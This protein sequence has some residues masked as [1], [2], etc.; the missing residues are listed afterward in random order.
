MKLNLSYENE[1]LE[2]LK[3]LIREIIRT[4]NEDDTHKF[5]CHFA[6]GVR[7]FDNQIYQV[8]RGKA[9]SCT[10]IEIKLRRL[11]HDTF[12]ESSQSPSQ[13]IST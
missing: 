2:D 12:I 6:G 10:E 5:M 3:D 7:K 8:I 1:A 11:I 13:S 9:G 4:W